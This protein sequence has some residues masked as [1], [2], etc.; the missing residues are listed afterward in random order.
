MR[1]PMPIRMPIRTR[2]PGTRIRDAVMGIRVTSMPRP[3][4]MAAGTAITPRVRVMATAGATAIAMACPT[5]MT[6]ARSIPIATD[7]ARRSRGDGRSRFHLAV[8]GLDLLH[9]LRLQ[10]FGGDVQ[11]DEHSPCREQYGRRDAD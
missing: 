7:S 9:G 4:I 3:G 8:L 2:L 1:I 6:A 10:V 5:A 11:V